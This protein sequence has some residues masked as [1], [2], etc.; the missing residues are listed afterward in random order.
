[1]D[2]TK[3]DTVRARCDIDTHAQD[4]AKEFHP[5][6]KAC[7]WKWSGGL[8]RGGSGVPT[9]DDIEIT[10]RVLAG[11]LY[12]GGPRAVVSTGRLE[13]EVT[14]SDTGWVSTFAKVV[15]QKMV[16]TLHEEEEKRRRGQ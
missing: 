3:E 5:I 16:S 11:N 12:P 15:T 7:G 8:R 4:L 6:F 1:M 14:K 13:I 2:L 10:L 9:E